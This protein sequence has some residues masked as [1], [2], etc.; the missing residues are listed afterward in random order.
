VFSDNVF[1]GTAWTPVKLTPGK[2]KNPFAKFEQQQ[3]QQAPAPRASPT[4]GTTKLT[5][6][7]R[8]ALAKR[9]AEEEEQR[10]KQASWQ[11]PASTG[12]SGGSSSGRFGEKVAAAAVG[13]AI[14]GAAGV[15]LA[16]NEPEPQEEFVF[17]VSLWFWWK[18]IL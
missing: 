18:D 2:L 1:Q 4:G 7:E 6:S 12:L 17:S 16:S 15:A 9:Q 3:Q 5:W 13:G 14:I 8:Q 10:S 11:S